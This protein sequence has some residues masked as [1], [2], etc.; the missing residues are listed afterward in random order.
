MRAL[1]DLPPE[2]APLVRMCAALGPRFS[3]DELAAV[4][5]I[6]DVGARL[7]ALVRDHLMIERNGWYELDDA[8]LQDA[9]YHYTADERQ[10]VHHRALAYWL[11]HPGSNVVGWL[12]RIAH[13]A[14]GAGEAVIAA[15]SW[16][17]LAREAHR[18][19]EPAHAD[20]LLAR[21]TRLLAP[22]TPPALADALRAV[23]PPLT[24]A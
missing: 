14:T 7:A 12:A 22:Q 15:T 9:I 6:S 21:A 10:L 18:R 3:A 17:A 19:D 24:E 8:S 13:H 4:T 16:I 1:E 20:E 5:R 11:G 23:D 2:L